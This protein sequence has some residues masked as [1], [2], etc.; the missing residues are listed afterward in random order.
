MESG[1]YFLLIFG[2][3]QTEN[4]GATS[5]ESDPAVCERRHDYR[6]AA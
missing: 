4:V 1:N 2:E 6:S 3:F 5:G